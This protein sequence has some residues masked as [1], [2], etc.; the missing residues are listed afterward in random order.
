MIILPNIV[1]INRKDDVVP[2]EILMNQNEEIEETEELEEDIEY[3]P[4][5]S[6]HSARLVVARKLKTVREGCFEKGN[7]VVLIGDNI[8]KIETSAFA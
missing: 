8:G 7:L 4:S 3:E 2:K 6:L 1:E 5:K